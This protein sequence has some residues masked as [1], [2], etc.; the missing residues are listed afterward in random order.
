MQVVATYNCQI[1]DATCCTLPLRC[2]ARG[3]MPWQHSKWCLMT[4]RNNMYGKTTCKM[5]LSPP[6]Q[7]A[8][9]RGN[10][11]VRL[12]PFPAVT[13]QT[14]ANCHLERPVGLIFTKKKSLTELQKNKTCSH[15]SRAKA[16]LKEVKILHL[17]QFACIVLGALVH[18]QG[19]VDS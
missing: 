3:T 6:T 17:L 4:I 9:G 1:D 14:Q 5:Q 7:D 15:D 2:T 13:Y 18:R 10:M 16:V 12:V 19:G 8:L 11:Y